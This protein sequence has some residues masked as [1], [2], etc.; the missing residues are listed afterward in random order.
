MQTRKLAQ[1]IHFKRRVEAR[2]G[3]QVNRQVIRDIVAMIQSGSLEFAGRAKGAVSA[4]RIPVG[5]GR[6]GVILYD[7]KTKAPRTILTEQMWERWRTR[8][9][10][11]PSRPAAE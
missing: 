4:F 10:S 3:L 9:I 11:S 7:K 6:Y 1:H 5:D 2:F 8:S